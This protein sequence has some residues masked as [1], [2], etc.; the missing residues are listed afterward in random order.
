MRSS[1]LSVLPTSEGPLP[2]SISRQYL[3]GPVGNNALQWASGSA[4]SAS[5][6]VGGPP[7]C[8]RATRDAQ[9]ASNSTPAHKS[10]TSR[11]NGVR[12]KARQTMSIG[13]ALDSTG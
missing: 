11:S 4:A 7:C 10:S 12:P 9:S 5:A 8:S 3:S 2:T 6:K 1:I 13:A